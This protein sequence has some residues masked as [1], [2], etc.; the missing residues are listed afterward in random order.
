V[1]FANSN[2]IDQHR[3]AAK[4]VAALSVNIDDC[5]ELLAMLGLDAGQCTDTPD[6]YSGS[7]RPHSTPKLRRPGRASRALR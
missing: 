5:I 3:R 4:V 2:I 6:P 7:Q 1:R